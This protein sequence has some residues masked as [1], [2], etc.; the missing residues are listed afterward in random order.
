VDDFIA[1]RQ[2]LALTLQKSGFRVLQAKD[3]LEAIEQLEKNATIQLVICDVEMP[4]MNGFEF[5]THRRQNPNLNKT[6]VI[7]L[8]SRSSDKH[9]R[10]AMHLGATSYFTKPYLEREFIAAIKDSLIPLS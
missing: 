3:G 10:L 6:P 4:N 9:R 8:T 5:L 1:L 7:M 2:T